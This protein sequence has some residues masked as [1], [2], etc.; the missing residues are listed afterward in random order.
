MASTTCDHSEA[1]TVRSGTL[2]P[3][4][5]LE[6]YDSA[7]CPK[8]KAFREAATFAGEPEPWLKNMRQTKTMLKKRAEE[9][10]KDDKNLRLKR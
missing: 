7:W 5:E 8:C 9:Q 2:R 10:D 4:E 6:D 1:I 3:G